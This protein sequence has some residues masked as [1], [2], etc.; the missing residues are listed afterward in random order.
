MVDPS[1][2]LSFTN[3]EYE[4][5]GILATAARLGRSEYI[6]DKPGLDK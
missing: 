4:K 3:A 6:I 1:R 5:L 2:T